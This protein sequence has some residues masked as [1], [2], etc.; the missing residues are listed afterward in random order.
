MLSYEEVAR[1]D[2]QINISRFGVE[3]QAKLKA[4]SVFIAGAGGLGSPVAYYLA[5]AGIGR[6]RITDSET[7]ETSNLNRQLLHWETDIDAKKVDSA[8]SK[9]RK[10]NNRVNVET[11]A[12]RITEANAS[13]L[14]QG[15]DVIVDCLD[16]LSSRY[17]LNK[18][19]LDNNIPLIHGA[20]HGFEGRAM[21]IIPGRTA[22]LFCV[23]HG[24]APT[25]KT[26]VLGATAGIVGTIQVTEV[27]KYLLGLGSLLT[28]RLLVYDG[29]AM[30]WDDLKVK[31]DPKCPHCSQYL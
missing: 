23:Y 16:N 1:Y 28:N 14:V 12:E 2:R 26:P 3:G 11:V 27:V 13:K 9:L 21:T 22:C 6:L 5:A 17:L 31:R 19:A 30:K 15:C 24:E 4:A 29:L 8:A 25:G 18:A 20:V 10:L 7:V